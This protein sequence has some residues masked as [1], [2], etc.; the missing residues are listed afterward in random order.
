MTKREK[1]ILRY[2]AAQLEKRA[3]TGEKPI[4]MPDDMANEAV[5]QSRG[6]RFSSQYVRALADGHEKL[7]LLKDITNTNK[8]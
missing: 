6:F 8:E 4:N 2:I 7:P 5:G 1:A 3:G